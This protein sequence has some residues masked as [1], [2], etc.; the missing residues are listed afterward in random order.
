M[1]I[2]EKVK[3]LKNNKTILNGIFFSGFSFL[4]R[5]FSFL[6]LFVLANFFTPSEYGYLS[7]F[8]TVLMILSYFINMS[9]EGY[10]SVV[11]FKEGI[12]GIRNTSSGILTISIIV[13]MTLLTSLIMFGNHIGSIL[14]LPLSVL[15]L[16]IA[17]SFFTGFTNLNLNIF[18]LK[19]KVMTYGLFSCSNALFNFILTIVFVA[20][21]HAGWKGRVYAQTICFSIFG[22]IGIVYFYKN[23]FFTR[24]DFSYIKG[25]LMW[26]IPLIPHLATSFIRQG[27]DRYIINYYH[28]ID[29]VG[30]FS[31]AL[32]IA[33]IISMIG[34]GFN[35]S[36]SVDIFKVLGSNA[37]NSEK[38]IK[39]KHQRRQLIGVYA[40][41]TL[42]IA[43]IGYYTIPLIMPAYSNAMVYFVL[44]CGYGLGICLYLVYTNYLFYY[45][46]TRLIMY[47]TLTSSLFHLSCSLI[48]TRYS[49]YFTCGIYILSQFIV[50]LLI[51]YFAKHTLVEHFSNNE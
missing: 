19:E 18:R 13:S 46:K 41:I 26:S 39:L 6:L 3:S 51:R 20:L 9:T 5:G 16:A 24:P 10:L 22:I 50:V 48:L 23:K 21:F 28:S 17:I 34:M 32:N 2:R 15:F 14:E 44:L 47:V 12:T 37:L 36:N 43:T 35:Q 11:Y 33:N 25:M 38:Q 49:L 7:L 45:G 30:L 40:V 42:F 31:F 29:E 1:N 4:N 8:A 27:C